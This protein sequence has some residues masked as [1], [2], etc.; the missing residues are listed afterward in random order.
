MHH[1]LELKA[2]IPDPAAL[3]DR[4]IAAG[5]VA[6]F[7]GRMS[8]RRFDRAGELTARDE[9]LRVRRY[10]HPRGRI[11]AVL[12]WKGPVRRSPEGYKQR[13]ELE[14]PVAEGVA[15]P[16]ALLTALGYTAVHAIDR[17][18]EVYQLDGATIRLEEY[19]RMDPLLEVEGEP[20][21][22]ER[23]VAASGISREGFS[24]EPLTEFVRRYEARSGQPAILS[25][26]TSP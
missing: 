16:E 25:L 26:G 17:Y 15:S 20:E 14:L 10:H 19:P 22:I 13:E 18:V 11:E 8:D 1:E 5:A 23:G 24:S 7:R 6:G 21:A 3:R 12:G 9:V 2:V 4:L